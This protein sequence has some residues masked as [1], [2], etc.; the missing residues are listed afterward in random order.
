MSIKGEVVILSIW[1]GTSA[2]EP[3]ACLTSNSLS[4]TV[5]I[6][7]SQTKCNPGVI[8]KQGGTRSF[9]FSAEGESIDTTSV[10]GETAKASHDK[11][12]AYLGVFKS[13]KMTTGLADTTAYYG[14][15]VM[16]DLESSAEAGSSLVTFSVTLS[17]SDLLAE[18]EPA[19]Q[20]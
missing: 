11:L 4:E 13:V 6:I 1:D 14:N 12:R 19:T 16:S 20:Y 3:L 15:V 7:E 8:I 10:G 2:Y 5:D 18:T 17:G 9:E